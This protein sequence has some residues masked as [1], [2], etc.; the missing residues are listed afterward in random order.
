M[1]SESDWQPSLDEIK[2]LQAHGLV[3]VEWTPEFGSY[4]VFKCLRSGGCCKE[5]LCAIGKRNAD[6]SQCEYLSAIGNSQYACT[7]PNGIAADEARQIGKGCAAPW[8][9]SRQ[10]IIRNII[11]KA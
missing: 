10:P 3:T 11:A 9:T 1:I 5:T 6:T 4:F 7:H 2:E 8:H